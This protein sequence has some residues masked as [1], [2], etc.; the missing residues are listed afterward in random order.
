MPHRSHSAN[1]PATSERSQF[2]TPWRNLA[3]A[4]LRMH[5]SG[6]LQTGTSVSRVFQ[7]T[8]ASQLAPRGQDHGH[9]P[10]PSTTHHSKT[11]QPPNLISHLPSHKQSWL[12]R[13]TSPLCRTV[14]S[15]VRRNHEST[16]CPPRLTDPVS[17]LS[18]PFPTSAQPRRCRQSHSTVRQVASAT[19][20]PRQLQPTRQPTAVFKVFRP[21]QLA[22]S[23]AGSHPPLSAQRRD[24]GTNQR[25]NRLT[26]HTTPTNTSAAARE[27]NGPSRRSQCQLR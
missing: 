5:L 18:H 4:L 21:L 17:T 10:T 26:V 3:T 16:T 14:K 19:A 27:A 15:L 11:A 20:P 6:W 9:D 22:S 25:T 12:S 8:Q 23:H 24:D 1:T 2:Q 13:K 7:P